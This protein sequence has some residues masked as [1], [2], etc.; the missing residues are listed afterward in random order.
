[1]KKKLLFILILIIGGI[2]FLNQNTIV[3]YITKNYLYKNELI[4]PTQN[5]YKLGR[6]FK[7]VQ[8]TDQFTPK[9]K[10]DLLNIIYTTLDNGW[11][12][13]SFYCPKEYTTCI[14]DTNELFSNQS[15]LS[16]LNNFV[17]PFNS[18]NKMKVDMNSLG[19]VTIHVQKLYTEERIQQIN[20]KIDEIYLQLIKPEMNDHDKIKAI[21]DYIINH[22]IYDEERSVLILEGKEDDATSN[23]HT[24]YG[25]L[26]EGKAICGGYS[27]T[28]ALFLHKMNLP[29]FKVSTYDHVWNAV[30]V[31]NTWLHLDLTWDD[32][33]TS[34]HENILTH[35]FFLLTN[36]QLQQQNTGQHNFDKKI[37]SEI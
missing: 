24:A 10:Q 20:Q 17:H 27:D 2:A 1:M 12:K 23:S 35:T 13:F 5:S 14:K 21:H 37:Y 6:N 25:L 26:F 32:P 29:N 16:H 31:D 28:M 11:E 8:Y 15:D 34:T 7:Y 18:Y 4:I 22:T 9:N 33:V 3:T 30:K 36:D 19:K